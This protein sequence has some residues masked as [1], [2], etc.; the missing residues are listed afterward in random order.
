[1]TYLQSVLIFALGNASESLTVYSLIDHGDKIGTK[2][3][4]SLYDGVLIAS[5]IGLKDIGNDTFAYLSLTI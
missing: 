4:T 3:F 1:M 5:S 2:D